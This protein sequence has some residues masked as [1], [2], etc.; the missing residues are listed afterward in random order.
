MMGGRPA[1]AR[2]ADCGTSLSAVLADHAL[3]GPEPIALS[4]AALSRV[5]MVL[6]RRRIAPPVGVVFAS[7]SVDC[8][9]LPLACSPRRERRRRGQPGFGASTGRRVLHGVDAGRASDLPAS[10]DDQRVSL[11]LGGK[12]RDIIFADA[13]ARSG[14]AGRIGRCLSNQRAAAPSCTPPT[15]IGCVCLLPLREDPAIARIAAQMAG[16][17][18]SSAGGEQGS[19]P[20]L[21][22]GVRSSGVDPSVRRG[23]RLVPLGGRADGARSGTAASSCGTSLRRH[24]DMALISRE[25]SFRALR[26]ASIV[27]LTHGRRRVRVA[28]AT[29]GLT[30]FS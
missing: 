30:I 6:K 16:A 21:Q 27:S 29:A 7:R 13:A 8:G 3:N 4:R 28:N 26:I 24:A 2:A 22:G 1:A 25:G 17:P 23:P 5:A 14:E 9:G 10:G 12:G 18:V 11:D 20:W 15:G 19:A